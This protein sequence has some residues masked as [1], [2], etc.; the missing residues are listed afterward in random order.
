MTISNAEADRLAKLPPR[1]SL[2]VS[3]AVGQFVRS[4]GTLSDVARARASIARTLAE[5]MDLDSVG[6]TSLVLLSKEL[7]LVLSDLDPTAFDR[8]K[9][10]MQFIFADVPSVPS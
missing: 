3:L 10:F 9:A 6:S 4:L 7:R 1:G 5:R 2:A 8:D